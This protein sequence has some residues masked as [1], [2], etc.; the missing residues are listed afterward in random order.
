MRHGGSGVRPA[1]L[2]LGVFA[3]SSVWALT[4][5]PL[6]GPDEQAHLVRAASVVRGQVVGE[7]VTIDGSQAWTRVT[8][9]QWVTSAGACASADPEHKPSCD[10]TL[11]GT[12]RSVEAETYVGRYPPLYYALTGLPTLLLDGTAALYAARLMSALLVT[13]LAWATC[14]ALALG[15]DRTSRGLT[16]GL[17]A[18]FTPLAASIMGVVNPSSCEIAATTYLAVALC[19]GATLRSP[20]QR[21]QKA[22]SH[23]QLAALS[24]TA[25]SRG[26]GLLWVALLVGATLI[27]AGRHALWAHA[28]GRAK[29]LAAAAVAA[30]AGWLTFVGGYQTITVDPPLGWTSTETLTHFA[31]ILRRVAEEA[32]H[33]YQWLEVRLPIAAVWWWLVV[34]ALVAL[35]G[36]RGGNRRE[37]LATL[38]LLLA[39]AALPV[40]ALASRS[41]SDGFFWQGR[42]SL[43]LIGATLLFASSSAARA[44]HA[45]A[46]KT[47][48]VLVASLAAIHLAAL[49]AV[50]ARNAT[51]SWWE[52]SPWGPPVA[53]VFLVA[54]AAAGLFLVWFALRS[55]GS[56]TMTGGRPPLPPR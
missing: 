12:S 45:L 15:T 36:L 13:L 7:R 9:Q 52:R 16:W 56:T 2:A 34:A 10:E 31:P 22:L 46:G 5:A 51:G 49:H 55:A 42:Y 24:L 28:S 44:P 48:V 54:A 4:I 39:S 33:K 35:V 21:V 6:A 30:A 37:R 38:A 41:E 18:A 40:A 20:S 11:A 3:V 8:V 32:V 14:R 26:L 43:P 47:R 25:L 50:L 19:V 29:A 23:H 27:R 53:P 17:A 1:L